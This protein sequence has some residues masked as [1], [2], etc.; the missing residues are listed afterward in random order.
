MQ[1]DEYFCFGRKEQQS[2]HSALNSQS[3]SQP[4]KGPRQVPVWP[5]QDLLPSRPGGLPGEA[6]GRQV[7]GSYYHDPEVGQGMA[8]ESEVPQA[9]GSYL[10]PAEVL[11]GIPSPQ[12]S[13]DGVHL[14]SGGM[15]GEGRAFVRSYSASSWAYLF[16]NCTQWLCT[17]LYCPSCFREQ[18][19]LVCLMISQS[20]SSPPTLNLGHP[21]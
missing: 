19:Q 13:H 4:C 2:M 12:V 18:I 15:G 14:E 1:S 20:I 6:S 8:A 3:P 17:S 9:E 11:Q 10:I 7:P 5:H 21:V 16:L